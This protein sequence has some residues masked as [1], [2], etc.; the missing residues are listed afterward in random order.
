VGWLDPSGLGPADPILAERCHSILSGLAAAGAVR[1]VEV[2]LLRPQRLQAIFEAIQGF[3]V[4]AVH[5]TLIRNGADRYQP[6]TLDRLRSARR[7]TP[8][9][10]ADALAARPAAM[11]EVFELLDGEIDVLATIATPI[12]AP[13]IG[14]RLSLVSGDRVPTKKALLSMTAIWNLIGEP[15]ISVPAG[16]IDGLPIGMQLV[17]RHSLGP[18]I[19]LGSA[20]SRAAAADTH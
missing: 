16:H 12:T 1:L 13:S 11:A 9:E 17:T 7:V 4:A 8:Q 3:E 18:S 6:D 19:E 5:E 2:R 10:Y 15:A 20:I 14:E